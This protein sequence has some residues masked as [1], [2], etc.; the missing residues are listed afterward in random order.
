MKE[1][2][3]NR[4]VMIIAAAATVSI[5]WAIFIVPSAPPWTTMVSLGALALLLVSSAVLGLRTTP[6]TSLEAVI[7]SVDTEKPRRKS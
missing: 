2:V 1:L 3:S 7:R 6:P 5:L 4:R